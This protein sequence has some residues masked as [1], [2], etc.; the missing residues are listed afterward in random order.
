[1]TTP[2]RSIVSPQQLLATLR[3]HFLVWA[4]PTVVA[5]VLAAGYGVMRPVKWRASQALVVRDEAGG[6]TATRA[7]RFDTSEAMK[8]AQ[9]TVVQMSRNPSTIKAALVEA[10]PP[11]DS[12]LRSDWPTKED[13]E[14]LQGLITVSPPKGGEFGRNEVIYLSLDAPNRERAVALTTAVCNQLE[15]QLQELRKAKAQSLIDELE[16]SVSLAEADLAMATAKLEVTERSV[17]RDLDEL[18]ALTETNA[19]TSNLRATSNQ[20]KEEIRR[21]QLTHETNTEQLKL[22]TA[23][24]EDNNRL[25]AAPQR[26]YEQQPALKRL[27]DGLVDAQLQAAQL[28]GK[29]RA[30]HPEVK[31]ATL[32]ADEIR[33]QL[34]GEINLVVHNLENDLKISSALLKTLEGQ[35]A[36]L[37]SRLKEV[38]GLRATYANQ[39][40][41]VRQRSE[42][43]SKVIKDLADVRASQAAALSASLIARLDEPQPGNSPVGPSFSMIVMAGFGGGLI[44]GFGLVFLMAPL[45][46]LWGRRWTDYVGIGRRASDKDLIGTINPSGLP[47]GR[48]DADAPR[49]APQPAAK[50][51]AAPPAAKPAVASA[52]AKPTAVPSAPPR[53]PAPVSAAAETVI[54][55]PLAEQPS[56]AAQGA[57]QGQQP[58]PPQKPR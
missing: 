16:K 4:I 55:V 6:N 8:T 39:L 53:P 48:R 20:L 13:V 57:I 29:M 45:G 44:F 27:K 35:Y 32:A 36:E 42:N 34:N 50:P 41:A 9:E 22:L 49:S 28:A 38:S 47:Y 30:D 2:A 40:A 15:I 43:L 7:G 21:T 5:T 54:R 14:A 3:R 24:R 26:L 33:R 12:Q 25:L 51:P 52:P 56:R 37:D 10:G 23:A 46:N 17:G 19:G 1:M 18:R 31:A 58:T 11:V